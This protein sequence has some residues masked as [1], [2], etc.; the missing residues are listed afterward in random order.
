MQSANS[1]AG[2]QLFVEAVRRAG[3]TDS[4][5]LRDVLL[6]LKTTTVLG[7]FAIDERGFQMG[8]KAVT[9]QWQAGKR[10]V[11]SPDEMVTGK[12]WFPTPLWNTR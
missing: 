6:A 8:Q 1:Y 12:L 2:C 11:V 7:D 9:I 5:K 10:V 3:T 4:D